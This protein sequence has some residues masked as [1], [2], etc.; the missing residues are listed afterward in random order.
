[1]NACPH[2]TEDGESMWI[3]L[4]V[5]NEGTVRCGGCDALGYVR[6]RPGHRGKVM[7]ARL[8]RCRQKGCRNPVIERRYGMGKSFELQNGCVE[9]PVRKATKLVEG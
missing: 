9:H 4:P 8:Y 2:V 5:P 3:A 7:K 1:M 6:R